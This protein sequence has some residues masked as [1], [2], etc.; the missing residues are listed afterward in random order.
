MNKVEKHILSCI[1]KHTAI[2][3]IVVSTILSLI[4]RYYML[5]YICRDMKQ[6]LI[7]WFEEIREAGG[8]AALNRQVGNYNILYQTIIAIM[9]YI[10]ID[11]IYQYKILSIIFDYC[12]SVIVAIIV[13]QLTKNDIKTAI[14]YGISIMFPTFIMNSALWGQ[15][16]SIYTTFCLLAVLFYL[17]KKYILCFI[18]Y[19]VAFEFKLQAVFI[20]PFF[21]FLYLCEQKYSITYFLLIPISMI[22][23]SIGG[24]IQGRS[25][26]DV[27]TIYIDQTTS[28]NSMSYN[29][30]SL[31][32]IRNS[33]E[34][35]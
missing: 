23:L 14:A 33:H 22:L 20:M 5:D 4:A 24:I 3:L 13:N 11:P 31:W 6:S 30:P 18:A 29:Y 7:P 10:P 21:I 27:F 35:N 26:S 1:K 8:I 16:D 9:T 17:K 32:T 15:C 2:I 12:L 28:G 25:V 19:G 34:I